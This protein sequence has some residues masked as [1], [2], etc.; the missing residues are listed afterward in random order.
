MPHPSLL[1]PEPL[2]LRQPTADLNLCRRHSNTVVSVSVRSLGPGAHKVCLNP[3]HLWQELG[4]ILNMNSPLLPSCWGFSF[5]LRHWV[6]FM[7]GSNILQSAVV[8]QCVVVLES[9]RSSRTAFYPA[10][11]RWTHIYHP[12]TF[13]GT[14]SPSTSL[15]KWC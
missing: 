10:I 6:S 4:L 9:R 11:L 1:H 13:G 3:E 12:A 8:Q 15:M 2:P 14:P 5:A 7:V